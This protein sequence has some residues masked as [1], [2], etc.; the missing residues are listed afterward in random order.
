MKSER[1]H[2]RLMGFT[3]RHLTE[4]EPALNSIKQIFPPTL[5]VLQVQFSAF[6]NSPKYLRVQMVSPARPQKQ[7][8]QANSPSPSLT[9]ALCP[10][11]KLPVP[12]GWRDVDDGLGSSPNTSH[13]ETADFLLGPKRFSTTETKTRYDADA[14][15]WHSNA[16][17]V[18]RYSL[19]NC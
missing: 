1:E 13:Q 4:E 9:N 16:L 19:G 18:E 14:R 12:A 11:L 3:P 17:L 10:Y 8:H 6:I 15:S 5:H 2:G 7:N